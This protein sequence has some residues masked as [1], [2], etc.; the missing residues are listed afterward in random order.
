MS[1]VNRA[2]IFPSDIHKQIVVDLTSIFSF[3]PDFF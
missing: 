3:S 2:K 1:K